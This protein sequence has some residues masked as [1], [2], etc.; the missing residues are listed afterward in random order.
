MKLV[1]YHPLFSVSTLCGYRIFHSTQC[2]SCTSVI[3]RL[4]STASWSHLIKTLS[5]ISVHRCILLLK[6][7]FV[8]P[9]Q[10]LSKENIIECRRKL[11]KGEPKIFINLLLTARMQELGVVQYSHRVLYEIP[12]L[13]Y[14]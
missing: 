4:L 11:T 7:A 13:L 10:S 8:N 14:H 3:F 12:I 9:E 2:K 1:F 6:N 5:S